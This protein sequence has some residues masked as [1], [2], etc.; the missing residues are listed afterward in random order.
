MHVPHVVLAQKNGDLYQVVQFE[1]GPAVFYVLGL[2]QN[3]TD[4]HMKVVNMQVGARCEV[5]ASELA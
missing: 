3:K 4:G 5:R 2:D 1:T